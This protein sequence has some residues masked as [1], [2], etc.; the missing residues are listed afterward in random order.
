MPPVLS[1]M[2]CGNRLSLVTLAVAGLMRPQKNDLRESNPAAAKQ[3]ENEKGNEANSP[4]RAG[5]MR[6]I[7]D[8]VYSLIT[9]EMSSV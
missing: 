6:S 2:D 1:Q 4:G 7:R 3:E 8:Q 9:E 5:R